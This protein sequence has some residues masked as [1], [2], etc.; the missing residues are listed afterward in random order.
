[1][2]LSGLYGELSKTGADQSNWPE[3]MFIFLLFSWG[4]VWV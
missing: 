2:Y 1:M 3:Q 4:F